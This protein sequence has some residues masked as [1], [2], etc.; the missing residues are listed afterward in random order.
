MP[1]TS[2]SP[3]NRRFRNVRSAPATV[4]V[5]KWD[6]FGDWHYFA[7]MSAAAMRARNP[8]ESDVRLID[9]YF[10]DYNA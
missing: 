8:R 2:S 3:T 10:Y 1:V 9:E 5:R 4:C 6:R 7:G